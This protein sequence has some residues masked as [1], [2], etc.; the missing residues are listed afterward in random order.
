MSILTC[1]IFSKSWVYSL[2][3]KFLWYILDIWGSSFVKFHDI[4]M[5]IDSHL[6][7]IN[8]VYAAGIKQ[9]TVRDMPKFEDLILKLGWMIW[10]IIYYA[11]HSVCLYHRLILCNLVWGLVLK[12]EVLN[13]VTV[14]FMKLFY[15]T[16]CMLPYECI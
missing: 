9:W 11:H 8:E 12:G 16:C 5:W 2:T 7:F 3:P 1:M 14:I 13:H 15:P 6:Y 10:A 4:W